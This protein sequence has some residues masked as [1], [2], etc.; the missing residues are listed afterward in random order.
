MN[1]WGAAQWI[2]AA[3]LTAVVIGTPVLRSLMI[4]SGAKGFVPWRD[5][6]GKWSIDFLIKVALVAVLYWGGFWL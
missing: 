4:S 3:Y 5:F 1:S 6:W 2:V